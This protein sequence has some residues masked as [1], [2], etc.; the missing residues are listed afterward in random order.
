MARFPH[1]AIKEVDLVQTAQMLSAESILQVHEFTTVIDRRELPETV[2][3]VLEVTDDIGMIS[4]PPFGD[5]FTLL[6]QVPTLTWPAE[7]FSNHS[8]Q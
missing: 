1:A 3:F 7:K 5:S 2:G 6:L 4:P 8:W